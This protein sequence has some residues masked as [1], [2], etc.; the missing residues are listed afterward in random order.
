MGQG[1][2]GTA[3]GRPDKGDA[4]LE[5]EPGHKIFAQIEKSKRFKGIVPINPSH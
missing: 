3:A 1:A 4:T 5:F 2:S